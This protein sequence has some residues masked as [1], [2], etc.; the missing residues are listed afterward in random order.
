MSVVVPIYKVRLGHSEVETPDLVLGVTNV[1]RGDNTVRGILK[2]GDDLVLSVLQA[3]NG[4]ALVGTN[5][6]NFKSTI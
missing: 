2:G 6:L 4:E 3:R 5:G 1:M